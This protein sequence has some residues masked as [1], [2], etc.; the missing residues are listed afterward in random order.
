MIQ[1]K[2][3]WY[4]YEINTEGELTEL[5]AE[6]DGLSQQSEKT[7]LFRGQ[8][9]ADWM[10]TSTFYRHFSKVFKLPEITTFKELLLY[11]DESTENNDY[12][13]IHDKMILEFADYCTKE[14]GL[15]VNLPKEKDKLD[16]NF[17]LSLAQH[18]GLPT[19][20]IDL[21]KSPYVALFF[22][23]D[24]KDD[25][26]HN[27]DYVCL[28]Q[29]NT[30][31]WV[32]T[33]NKLVLNGQYFVDESDNELRELASE[34]N[35]SSKNVEF[36]EL[37]DPCFEHNLRIRNQQ[38]CVYFNSDAVPYDVLMYRMKE[39]C[40]LNERRIK[41]NRNL[42]PFVMD[43]LKGKGITHDFIYPKSELDRWKEALEKKTSSLIEEYKNQ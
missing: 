10:I 43:Y 8:H 33:I 18:Y 23:F 24:Y 3:F 39:R 42:K 41:I 21:T 22:A 14:L 37:R 2:A 36:P 28:F 31:K 12:S 15:I 17:Y 20:L 40:S 4:T 5:L 16:A 7:L 35:F 9:E 25:M 11:L 34:Y 29:T 27:S 1:D 13:V 26:K 30:I 38:G 32:D 19:N 6:L